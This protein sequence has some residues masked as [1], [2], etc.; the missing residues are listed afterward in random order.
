MLAR[1]HLWRNL[2]II[3]GLIAVCVW[4][5]LLY[6]FP[7][8]T[9]NREKQS[10]V[11]VATMA[12]GMD[13]LRVRMWVDGNVVRSDEAARLT[14]RFE[15]G[16]GKKI[17]GLA[18]VD[19]QERGF[20][21]QQIKPKAWAM[22]PGEA[23]E[24][25]PVDLRPSTNGGQ[26]R[27]T[28]RYRVKGEDNIVHEGVIASAP[29]TIRNERAERWNQF[30]RRL[31]TVFT[32]P[33]FL[34]LIGFLL[35]QRQTAEARRQEIWKTLLP[36]F[37]T[38]SEKHYLP[39]VRTLQKIPSLIPAD[40]AMA[41][42]ERIHRLMFEFLFLL[43]QMS[44][45]RKRQGQFFFKNRQGEKVASYAWVILKRGSD[46]ML[47]EVRVEAVLEKM[48]P[49]MTYREFCNRLATLPEF[50]DLEGKF[51]AWVRTTEPGR[52]FSH[53]GHLVKI[54]EI[55]VYFEAN[56]PFDR[57]WY[58]TAANFDLESADKYHFPSPAAVDSKE[59]K[60]S[61]QGRID[62]LKEAITTYRAEVMAYLDSFPKK[63]V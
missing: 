30:L 18:V 19:E 38:L 10:A 46:E 3:G 43:L 21:Y 28:V 6:W 51:V 48:T 33:L 12:P 62:K 37:H 34:G 14:L 40:P 9:S 59:V 63:K 50:M 39:V 58:G 16:T 52:S 5:Y 45:F 35:Q 15:N 1:H 53:Y 29:I 36:T 20:Q 8:G 25:E 41:T 42:V 22:L 2:A 61:K 17:T 24:S 32:L 27:V 7:G 44:I 47:G 49:K 11:A 55:A 26:Y 4:L 13:G 31:P 54:M 56:R 57:D 23:V 60:E